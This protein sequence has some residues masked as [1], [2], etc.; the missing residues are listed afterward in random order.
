ME[1]WQNT[2]R[3]VSRY[4]EPLQEYI[5]RMCTSLYRVYSIHVFRFSRQ[6]PNKASLRS[7][8]HNV[9]AQSIPLREQC[10]HPDLILFGVCR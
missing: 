6:R 4:L 7:S 5:P 3:M 9:V 2:D 10:A 1:E 8:L